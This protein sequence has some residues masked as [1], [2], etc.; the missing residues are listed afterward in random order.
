MSILLLIYQDEFSYTWKLNSRGRHVNPGLPLVK[1]FP[2]PAGA[3]DSHPL[4]PIPTHIAMSATSKQCRNDA[5]PIWNAIRELFSQVYNIGCK[6]TK[7]PHKKL[8]RV[9]GFCLRSDKSRIDIKCWGQM[10][11]ETERRMENLT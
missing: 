3:L 7:K 1:A 2:Q 5:G 4:Q 11:N 9:S 6:V 8:S 10:Y